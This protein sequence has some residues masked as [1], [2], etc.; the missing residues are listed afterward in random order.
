MRS[1]AD[2]Q[3]NHV[4]SEERAKENA[5]GDGRTLFEFSAEDVVS[6]SRRDVGWSESHHTEVSM[7]TYISNR[8]VLSTAYYI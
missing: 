4:A 6:C 2:T 7:H 1:M 8:A 5:K 3:E